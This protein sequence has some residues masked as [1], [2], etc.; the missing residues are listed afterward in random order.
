MKKLFVGNLPT[1]ATEASVLALFSQFGKVRSIELVTDLFNG[2]CKG[3]GF[4]GM[5]GHEA[6]AA[7]AKLDGFM[8]GEKPLKV[9]F[10]D[11]PNLGIWT[12]VGAPFIC[13]EPWFGYSDTIES[14][15]NL[16]EKEG[17]IVLEAND[18]FQTKFSLEI[19]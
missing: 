3:F 15:G 7:I 1:D 9:N 8:Y 19:L 2:R 14:N 13:I 11:F 6:R 12:K 16:F 17:V 10:E 18:T 5:E 4:I